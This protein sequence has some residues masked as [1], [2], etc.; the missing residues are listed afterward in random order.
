MSTTSKGHVVFSVSVHQ[1]TGN[2]IY[3]TT[4]LRIFKVRISL[5]NNHRIRQK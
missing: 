1:G 3:V 4:D 5:S 2:D